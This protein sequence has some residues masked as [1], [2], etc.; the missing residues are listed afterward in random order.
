MPMHTALT[1]R[2]LTTFVALGVAQLSADTVEIK[3]G[4]RITGKI[5]SIDA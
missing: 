3:N 2:L 5:T 1:T 4:S